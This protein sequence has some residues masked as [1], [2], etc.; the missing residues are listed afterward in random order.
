VVGAIVVVGGDGSTRLV[1]TRTVVVCTAESVEPDDLLMPDWAASELFVRWEREALVIGAGVDAI[2]CAD[3]DVSALLVV[4]TVVTGA[5][6]P[7]IDPG[8][9][10]VGGDELVHPATATSP[11]RAITVTD[12]RPVPRNQR[13]TPLPDG[14][15]PLASG[16]SS[17]TDGANTLTICNGARPRLNPAL[18]TTASHVL[19]HNGHRAPVGP[20]SSLR[21]PD[22][23]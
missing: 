10:T 16:T 8:P 5:T 9:N 12:A 2:S 23:R 22:I 19:R 18:W 17:T 4:L 20:R 21:H 13:I 6:L 1:V 11:A 7:V 14:A 15:P 3:D